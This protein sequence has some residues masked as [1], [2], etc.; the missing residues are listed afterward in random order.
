MVKL[1]L[2]IILVLAFV[3]GAQ[4]HP[5]QEQGGTLRSGVE[6]DFLVDARVLE[7]DRSSFAAMR[8]SPSSAPE[9]AARPAGFALI[10]S[11]GSAQS[12]ATN[13]R[14]TALQRFQFTAS[15]RKP[16]QTRIG[17]RIPITEGADP[18]EFLDAGINLEVTSA[19]TS[20]REISMSLA[21]QV[22]VRRGNS[23]IAGTPVFTT[24][25]VQHEVRIV[26]GESVLLGGFI[27]EAE[28]RSMLS[29]APLIRSP[30][31]G[32]L[33]RQ[34]QQ[35]EPS[36]IVIMLTPHLPGAPIT[37]ST[38]N[39]PSR[40]TGSA[41]TARAAASATT[42]S[43]SADSTASGFSAHATGSTALTRKVHRPVGCLPGGRLGQRSG[44]RIGQEP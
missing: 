26:A 2:R 21:A 11:S 15:H 32:Y 17:S 22:Q 8:T 43:A 14:S 40:T 38:R 1:T 23:S 13:P 42:T 20:V 31:L 16:T 34:A 36:E 27:S 24:R 28:A 12:L 5:P 25:R 9:S 29:I 6:P 44:G 19:P 37:E 10:L 41:G 18:S 4:S 33:F 7:V 3:T 35:H 39:E 30:I